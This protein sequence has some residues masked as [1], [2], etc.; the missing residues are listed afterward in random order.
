MFLILIS[1][2]RLSEPHGLVWPDELG[3]LKNSFT[4]SGRE[5]FYHS[6]STNYA[7]MS[8]AVEHLI[9]FLAKSLHCTAV[10]KQALGDG[11]DPSS[12]DRGDR[13]MKRQVQKQTG[14]WTSNVLCCCRTVT[15]DALAATTVRR[16][17]N[18]LSGLGPRANYTDRATAACRRSECQ[19][20]QIEGATWPA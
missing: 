7:S 13:R 18:K 9:P 6:A 16:K 1:V 11:R 12:E 15:C 4:S 17:K 20:L 19:L 3:E 8:E 2:K 10:A 14:P 5:P